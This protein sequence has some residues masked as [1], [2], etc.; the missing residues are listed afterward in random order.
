LGDFRGIKGTKS[1]FSEFIIVC[2]AFAMLKQ[3]DLFHQHTS[4]CYKFVRMPLTACQKMARYREKLKQDPIKMLIVKQKDRERKR[5]SKQEITA[6]QRKKAKC[7]NRERVQ[8]HR[9]KKI[10]FQGVDAETDAAASIA[11]PTLANDTIGISP[12]TIGKAVTKGNEASSEITKKEKS[13]DTQ[14]R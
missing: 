13:C 1:G 8:K 10:S 9:A 7:Q 4:S 5:R 12:Q 2:H 11:D 3:F 14:S 6:A